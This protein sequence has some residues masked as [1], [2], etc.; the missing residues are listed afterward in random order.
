[1]ATIEKSIDVEVPVAVAY[2]QWTQFEEFPK[3]MDGIV[4]VRQIDDQRLQWTAEVGGEQHEWV[5]EIVEQVPDR[6]IAWRSV[7]GMPNSGRV[8]FEPIA[9]GTRVQVGMEYEPEGFKESVGALFGIDGRQVEGDLERFKEL[10]ESRQ[11]PTGEW[12]GSIESGRV[13]GDDTSR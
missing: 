9:D 3:F 4:G 13:E 11:A 10:V 2:G 7:E 12:R 6:V 8:E 5:A 1:M